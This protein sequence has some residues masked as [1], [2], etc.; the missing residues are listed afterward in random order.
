MLK[1]NQNEGSRVIS[2]FVFQILSKIF[3]NL[4]IL[5]VENLIRI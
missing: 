4:A 5:F 3:R 1:R 2:P